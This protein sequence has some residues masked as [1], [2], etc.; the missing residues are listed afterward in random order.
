MK[1]VHV[2]TAFGI[3]GAEK[4]LLNVIHK[5]VENNAVCL[6]YFKD[7]NDLILELDKRVEVKQIPLSIFIIKELKNYFKKINPDI[8]H[9]HLGHADLLGAWS[10]RNI[11]AKLFCT[12]HNIYFK[13][14]LIDILFFKYILIYLS[15]LLR[16]G[17]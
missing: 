1:I 6:V 13:K 8:I 15:M 9:T 3:G 10:A 16:K 14:K 17:K 7:K 12:M 5:Q 11:R 4:L 2:I